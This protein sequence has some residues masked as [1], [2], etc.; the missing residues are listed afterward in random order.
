MKLS[1]ELIVGAVFLCALALLAAFTVVIGD[2]SIF[3][4]DRHSATVEF[5][6]VGGLKAGDE[7][8]VLGLQ[9]GKVDTL[10]TSIQEGQ[11][12]AG[13]VLN[14]PVEMHEGYRIR[15]K[16]VSALGGRFV[17]IFPG[18]ADAPTIPADEVLKGEAPKDLFDA[19]DEVAEMVKGLDLEG[20]GDGGL[21]RMLL[22]GES[23]ASVQAISG[24]LE[25]GEGSLGKLINEDTLYVSAEA[26]MKNASEIS[27]KIR[28]GEGAVGRL[29]M[30]DKVGQDLSDSVANVADITG[31]IKDA[32]GT[33]G[34]LVYKENL[35]AGAGDFFNALKQTANKISNSEG[36]IGKL[37]NESGLY[38]KADEL[39]TELI[40]A[41]EDARES[42]PVTV[43]AGTLLA[44]F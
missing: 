10:H 14:E 4:K 25:R 32:K 9:V 43:F 31:A 21:G 33:L 39:L 28:S 41:V 27:A 22:G 40:E 44:G 7:V 16:S 30:K 29:I 13:L 23:F 19:L 38:D 12:I 37:I 42:A 20:L 15:I 8:R 6:D 1:T 36:T 5:T 18:L 11:V 17:S 34:Q 3:Y 26:T 35:L 24:K 2:Y